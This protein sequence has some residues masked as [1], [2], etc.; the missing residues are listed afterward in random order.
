MGRPYKII[1]LFSV[2]LMLLLF[3]HDAIY[4][5]PGKPYPIQEIITDLLFAGT[6]YTALFF[7]AI[8]GVYYLANKIPD[9]K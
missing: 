4:D 2:C 3:V 5:D 6:M 1:L 7:G 9:K 8:A